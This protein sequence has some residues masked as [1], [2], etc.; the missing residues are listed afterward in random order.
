MR[1]YVVKCKNWTPELY[2]K[3][4][5]LPYSWCKTEGNVPSH[6]DQIEEARNESAVISRCVAMNQEYI[7][8]VKTDD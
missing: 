7:R 4:K 6:T 8:S 2:S 1:Y 3:N 5:I